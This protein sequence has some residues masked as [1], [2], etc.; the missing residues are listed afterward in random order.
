L[1][2][3]PD[4]S[5]LPDLDR[6]YRK[7]IFGMKTANTMSVITAD[8][9]HLTEEPARVGRPTS[10]PARPEPRIELIREGDIIR[11]IEVICSCG[12]RIKIRC[13]YE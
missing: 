7:G 12:E 11:A 2:A 13:D 9:V 4:R 8:H 3:A 5:Q 10:G 6:H 1:V